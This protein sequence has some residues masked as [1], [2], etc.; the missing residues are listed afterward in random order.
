MDKASFK[1]NLWYITF[2]IVLYV[3]LTNLPVVIGLLA[4]VQRILRPL[5]LGFVIAYLLNIPYKGFRKRVFHSLEK[6]GPIGVKTASVLSVLSTYVLFFSTIAVLVRF[7]IPQLV[8]SIAQLIENIPT[9]I[10]TVENWVQYLDEN[11][12]LQDM[13]DWYD[14]DLLDNLNTT[15]NQAVTRWIP[16]I[17]NYLL[18]LTSGLYN[19][20][21]GLVISVY[22]L[23]SK[24]VLVE[25]TTRLSKAICPQPFF[26]RFI[27]ISRRTNLI[28]NRFI[29]G[30]VI[31]AL[32]IGAICFIA[33]NL[34]KMPYVLLVTV[35]IG[36][37]N[38]I[39]IVGP[40]I[41]AIPAIFIIMIVDPFKAF[42][43]FLFII[44]LQQLDGNVIK[45]KVLGN[46]V[47]LPGLWVLVAIILGAGL[48]GIV[49]MVLGVPTF[50][51]IYS[52]V[53]EWIDRRLQDGGEIC[54]QDEIKGGLGR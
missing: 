53:G 3:G 28:F 4:N 7:I 12:G 32:I 41:G 49:G 52:L 26:G 34:M 44:A 15:L 2:G 43:F 29:T 51:I 9:Y 16:I 14:S 36:V 17:G 18:G 27:E 22:F 8:D 33:M 31:D 30:N 39:P 46:T 40:F 48:Y 19:W 10:V 35:I 20:I 54:E 5:L 1:R 45:P 6:K 21:I 38:L 24:E 47:G 13:I 37:T 50:A 25:Q 23:Y 11:F 42:L